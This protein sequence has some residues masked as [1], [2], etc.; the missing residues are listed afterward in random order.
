MTINEITQKV[1]ELANNWENFKN[2]NDQRLKEIEKKG[3]ADCLTEMNLKRLNDNIDRYQSDL[4]KIETVLARPAM[5][6]KNEYVNVDGQAHSKAFCSYL[7]KGLE[8]GLMDIEQKQLHSSN[9]DSGYLITNK[10]AVK[11]A[12]SL[13]ENSPLRRIANV[14]E[15]SSSSLEIIEDRFESNAG[16]THDA[17][18]LDEAQATTINKKVIPVHELYAQ[19]KLTQRLIDDTSI[20]LESWLANKLIEVFHNKENNAFISGDGVGKPRG[21]LTYEAGNDWGKVEQVNTG[22]N[23]KITSESM[24]K[25]FFSLK[26]NYAQNAKFLMSRDAIQSVRT[27]KESAN[28]RYIWQPGLEAKVPDRLMGLEVI[29]APDMP[30][31]QE[32]SL[33][34]VLGNFEYGYQIV[35]RQ[36]IRILRDPFTNKPF[37]KFYTTKRVGGDVINFD[38]LKILKLG[39]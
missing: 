39:A 8:H 25:L 17:G 35:D 27:L 16:W 15:V 13:A 31:M 32:N 28:G 4:K 37:V 38:A 5:E 21:I 6:I 30:K 7:R 26:E 9:K 36:D 3:S 20:D 14:V 22:V 19:P 29:E 1:N 18:D 34:V 33:S 2:I 10:M 11:I 12:K 23:G 24:I